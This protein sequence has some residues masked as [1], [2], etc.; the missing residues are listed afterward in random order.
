MPSS[1]ERVAAFMGLAGLTCLALGAW[2][3]INLLLWLGWTLAT[4]LILGAVV[5][6]VIGLPLAFLERLR[7]RRRR[8]DGRR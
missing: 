2:T 7:A 8:G 5:A 1:F 6:A 4:P 3:R